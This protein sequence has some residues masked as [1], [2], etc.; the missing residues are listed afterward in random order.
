MKKTGKKF[1]AIIVS[2]AVVVGSTIGAFAAEKAGVTNEYISYAEEKEDASA[3]TTVEEAVSENTVAV[4]EDDI[5]NDEVVYVFTDSNGSVEKVMD[6]I[7]IKDGED[8]TQT[9][10]DA[11]LP[12]TVEVKYSLDGK[13]VAPESLS[14]K[15]GHLKAEISFT[16]NRYE[17]KE[18]NGNEEK[19]YVPFLA[20]AVTALD[21][22]KYSNV[23]VSNGRVI[24]DGARYAVVGVALPGLKEDLDISANEV[25]IPESITIEADVEDFEEF[26]MY[27]LVTNS[28]FNEIDID[29]TEKMDELREDL[30]K[31]DDAMEALMNGSDELYDGLSKLLDGANKFDDGMNQLSDGLN[32]LDSNSA[33]LVDGSR[34][35]FNTLLATA[36][37][38]LKASGI[39]VGNL[40]IDNYDSVLASV[41]SE[42][43]A[44]KLAYSAVEAKVKENEGT[45][46]NAVT[47]AVN[48]QVES[49]VEDAVRAGVEE[50][51]TAA[52]RANVEA[53]VTAAVES[54]VRDQ[55][56]A[57]VAGNLGV[58]VEDALASPEASAM[59]DQTVAAKMASDDIK[60][61][62]A[63]KTDAQMA[64]DSVKATINAKVDE[65]MATPEVQALIE[66]TKASKLSS[67][68]VKGIIDAKTQETINSKISEYENSPE[69]Q[70]QI[71][72]GDK[73][74][75]DLKASL[76]SY[77]TYYQGVI[78]YTN[79]VSKANAGAKELNKNMP[80]L[81]KGIQALKDGEK[82]LS[83]GLTQFNDEGV[84][85]LNDLVNNTLEGMVERFNTVK[86]VSRDYASYGT[87]GED[88]KDGVRFIYKIKTVK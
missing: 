19:I 68:E 5:S 45:I 29:T 59:I 1:T 40:T 15:S 11:D 10:A 13:E 27:L 36:S 69:V 14:G 28:V 17:Y 30:G 57:T 75:L 25:E 44:K 82:K 63:E 39:N 21:G 70:A 32:T 64:S 67:D 18:I 41:V 8:K 22:E 83:D 24:N 12:L 50:K 52:V 2:L 47:D 78:A 61:M 77:N 37:E 56:A 35:V 87:D 54:G 62:I 9:D 60:A 66:S 53:Q 6:S 3:E 72:A 80:E 4:S 49:G 46:R 71:S 55:V 73:K 42:G 33:A 74:I 86:E 43:Y 51:V 23:T 84:V 85:K 81:V 34:Q 48:A 38:Q 7:W 31:I 88:T 58:S 20:S 26:G 79:G 16:D 65:Q 76:D